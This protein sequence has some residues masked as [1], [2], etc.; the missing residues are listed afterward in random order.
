MTE[1]PT[2]NDAP[3]ISSGVDGLDTVLHGGFLRGAIYIVTGRPGAG[4]TILANQT[5]FRHVASGGR[6]VYVTLLSEMHDALLAH[7]SRFK[8]FER[9]AVGSSVVYLN[10]YTTLSNG[11]LEGLLKVLRDSIRVQSATLLVVDGMLTAEVF[12]RS[13][14]EYKRFIQELQ[15]WVSLMG[16]TVLLLTSSDMREGVK[17]E[18]TMVDSIVELRARDAG[19]RWLRELEV[20]KQ[21]GSGFLEGRHAYSITDEGLILFPRFEALYG[22]RREGVHFDKRISI[23][24]EELD[25]LMDG[26]LLEGSTTLVLG[27]SGS[28]KTVLGLHFLHAGLLAGEPALC[29]GFAENPDTIRAIMRRLGMDPKDLLIEWQPAAE[30]LLDAIGYRIMELV[31][32][33]GVRRLL[34]DGVDGL[35]R[36]TSYPERVPSFFSVLVEELC[37]RGV[38]TIVTDETREMFAEEMELPGLTMSAICDNSITFRQVQTETQISRVLTILK[39]S[40]SSHARGL[41]VVEVTDRGIVIGETLQMTKGVVTAASVRAERGKGT[42]KATGTGARA[43]KA[44]KAAG[45]SRRK[46]R[47]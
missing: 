10:G 26:G 17:P 24:V 22:A 20:T 2:P 19:Q 18:H 47:K 34:I 40:A 15:S 11:G 25:R 30:L 37:A 46:T 33:H 38:T 16:V 13:D 4:K 1:A 29:M 31:Q 41:Y 27:A 3:R 45:S 42:G 36:A 35:S 28:G 43:R 7:M 14:V 12:A 8:F 9:S 6:A 39:T 23:G 5:C 21:R 44:T 32:K